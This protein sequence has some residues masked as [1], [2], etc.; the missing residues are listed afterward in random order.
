[1]S[2]MSLPGPL[3]PFGCAALCRRCGSGLGAAGCRVTSVSPGPVHRSGA[4]IRPE[5]G[6]LLYLRSPGTPP[7]RACGDRGRSHHAI[8]STSSCVKPLRAER[9]AHGHHRWLASTDHLGGGRLGGAGYWVTVSRGG[10][11]VRAWTER[12]VSF[13][14]GGH[15]G[16]PVPRPPEHSPTLSRTQKHQRA[17]KQRERTTATGRQRKSIGSRPLHTSEFVL[18]TVED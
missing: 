6:L 9:S 10:V 12:S 17:Q 15:G 8:R 2:S 1:V 16:H 13:D 3:L 11:G 4:S 14:H 7:P 18:C 5:P